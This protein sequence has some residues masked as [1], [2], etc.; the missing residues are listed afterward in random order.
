M[1]VI[2]KDVVIGNEEFIYID[3]PKAISDI[4]GCNIL[5]YYI[6]SNSI[7]VCVLNV[8]TSIEKKQIAQC[9]PLLIPKHPSSNAVSIFLRTGNGQKE[10][11]VIDR[12]TSKLHPL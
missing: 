8:L 1:A 12:N 5:T 11:G 10:I 9:G 6:E 4:G 2:I 7:N 3:I